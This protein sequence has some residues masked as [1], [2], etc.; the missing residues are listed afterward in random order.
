MKQLFLILALVGGMLFTNAQDKVKNEYIKD[1]KLIKATLYHDNGV[2]SQKGFYT[3]DGKLQGTWVSFDE[4][5][6]KTAEAHYNKGQKTGKWFFWQD[7][8]IL[9]EVDYSNSKITSVNTW[10]MQGEQVVSS[11]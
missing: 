3:K 8:N 6:K 1:G 2:V 9:K 7:G 11:N 5:G 4:N 10:K